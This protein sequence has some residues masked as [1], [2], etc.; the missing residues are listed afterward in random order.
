MR[1]KRTTR[2][3]L[4][5]GLAAGG[6][7]VAAGAVALYALQTSWFKQQVRE[8]II[9]AAEQA[10][11]GRVELKAFNY[12]W[13]TL[14]AEFTGFVVH[15][16]EGSSAPA[17]FR[18]DSVQ[19][20]LRLVSMLKRNVDLASVTLVRPK[21]HLVLHPDG[22]TN[23][24]QP[25]LRDGANGFLQQLFSLKIRRIEV[26]NG[27]LQVDAQE[28]PLTVH[29]NDLKVELRYEAAGSQ[30]KVS[31]NSRDVQLN[32][33]RVRNLSGDVAANL[34][35][36]RDRLVIEHVLVTSQKSALSA[37]GTVSHFANPAAEIALDA[38]VAAADAVR[39]AGVSDLQ[40]GEL[41]V[42]GTL[43]YD[44]TAAF[45]F[46]GALMGKHLSYN[47]RGT[48][49]KDMDLTSQIVVQGD[50][51]TFTK[52]SVNPF[53]STL[54]GDAVLKRDGSLQF[55]GKF[56]GWNLRRASSLLLPRY[57][58]SWSGGASGVLHLSGTLGQRNFTIRSVARII[59][60]SGGI[61]VSGDLDVSYRQLGEIL[62]LG[63]SHLNL[64]HTQVTF[65]GIAGQNLA[66]TLDTTDLN[67][68]RLA[69]S[70]T[71]MPK[72]ASNGKLHF[73]GTIS[74]LLSNPRIQ[75]DVT[76]AQLSFGKTSWRQLRARMNL[77][78]D[79]INC[80]SFTAD[81]DVLRISGAGHATLENWALRPDGAFALNA[82][83][84]HADL[85]R[86]AH[87]LVPFPSYAVRGIGSGSVN[88]TGSPSDPR[89]S[90]SLRINDLDGYGDR[91]T[92]VRLDMSLDPGQVRIDRG[93]VRSGGAL[94]IFSGS[95]RHQGGLWQGGELALK[96]DSNGFPLT[97]L[98][99]VRNYN[100]GLEAL[101]EVHLR[102][103]ARATGQQVLPT[104]AD[105]TVIFRNITIQGT[106]YGSVTAGVSTY[107]Q[108]LDA[109]FS[110][111]LRDT[112]LTGRARVQLSAGL[113]CTGELHLDR[114]SL[115]I[116]YALARPTAPSPPFD[117]FLQ[118]DATFSGPLQHPDQ[119]HG[120]VKLDQLE[121]KSSLRKL[122]ETRSEAENL[123]FRNAGPILLDA[124]NGVA[125]IRSFE[126]RGEAT[127]LSVRGA[128]PYSQQRPVDLRL[129]GS[130]DL[131]I[132]QLFDP[133]VHS[134]GQS[135]IAT[136]VRGTL[137]N[138]V[139]SGAVQLK[140]GSFSLEGVPNGLTGVNGLV[141][142]DRDRATIQNLTGQTGGG[143]VSLGGFITYGAGGPFIYRLEAKAEDVRVRY[144]G[145]AS[146][147]GNANLRLTGTSKSSVL[148]GT[149]AI[150]R[151]AFT[152]NT[153]VGNLLAA[154]AA[155]SATP[156]NDTDFLAG[157][158]LNVHIENA[159]NLQLSTSLSRDV[160]ASID[161]RLRG[162]P[163]HPVLLGSIS[164]NQGDIKVFGTK[165]S[166]NRGEVKFVN[167]VKI[168]PVL[169][170]DLQTQARGIIVD[171]TIAGALGKLNINYRSDPPLQPRD[172]IALLTV[173]HTPDVA[174]N[175]SGSQNTGNASALQSD[176]NTVLGA[177]ISPA[178]SRLQ[179]L[180]GVANIKIDP[181]VQGITNTMQ[182]LTIEQQI[183][184]N[185]T[186][187]YVTNLSQTSEQIFRFEWA[188]SPQY[189]LVALRDDNGE[190]GIDIQ[191][192][193]RFK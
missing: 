137:A 138:P 37:H 193:K 101:V 94:L 52:L 13:R 60:G 68:M 27:L 147:T 169:D 164:A 84:D 145:S 24:P 54:T 66:L 72:V 17:L 116:L 104:H 88:V 67:D 132:F 127:T 20:G 71:S 126:I 95:Y 178:S 15:G 41:G 99:P 90:A 115:P 129:Q 6:L 108:T 10:S 16:R 100:P 9:A 83:F 81:S 121:L 160:E 141:N 161:L 157:L 190:F 112:H 191:Y 64:P 40:S 3:A 110:G 176:A 55:A 49:L 172:I 170:L 140:N 45:T 149:L 154:V 185:I 56:A 70:G 75:G 80:T 105:G 89:G 142:F 25:N 14:T 57:P 38:R 97:S 47:S 30:Y 128:I 114:M 144:G 73:E 19:V 152:P 5:A 167:P 26:R 85:A 189:S 28:F 153:D 48:L 63:K 82:Q 130:A 188:L 32:S 42:M 22:T 125:T 158:Q 119:I 187:T 11:G 139:I 34:V 93:T 131:R 175:I 7:A 29:G 148:S 98:A 180:F 174:A 51:A 78:E 117:G 183:S 2:R 106:R 113:A 91:N 134:S 107:G 166:I 69:L 35:L 150:S 120:T 44:S 8:K 173:G 171:I 165:Y 65:S 186:V 143:Q 79:A 155:P 179:K 135:L 92:S 18:S 43:H 123:V 102:A 36:T 61:P 156:A 39:F 58:I 1:M 159:P 151:A 50:Q 74:G 77:A 76:A 124:A 59:P 163:G 192:K 4:T 136:S 31:L 23:L 146:I 181:M 168:E 184:R 62:T 87:D 162:T 53:G 46:A 111:A 133:N 33:D 96:A 118:G 177:A 122:G 103:S 109:D 86:L 12:N 182:R 21:L